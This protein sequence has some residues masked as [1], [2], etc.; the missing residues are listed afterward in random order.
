MTAP[1]WGRRTRSRWRASRPSCTRCTDA[2]APYVLAAGS[3]G[4]RRAL[5]FQHAY[6]SDVVGMM[7]IDAVHPAEAPEPW[8]VEGMSLVVLRLRR[9]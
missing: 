5:A 4:G 6:P 2:P 3:K 8:Q 9:A 7:T 1:G